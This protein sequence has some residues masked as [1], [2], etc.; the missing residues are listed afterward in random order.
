M[1]ALTSTR[2]TSRAWGWLLAATGL[3]ALLLAVGPAHAED[4]AIQ[5]GQRLQGTLELPAEALERFR[6]VQEK[7]A[8]LRPGTPLESETWRGTPVDLTAGGSPYTLVLK[9][10]AVAIADGDAGVRMQ[11]SW[12][13]DG[14]TTELPMP[15]MAQKG[16]RAGQVVELVGVSAPMG[17]NANRQGVPVVEFTTAANLRLERVQIDVW[18]GQRAS[19]PV[20][21]VMSWMPMLFGVVAL[22]FFLWLRRM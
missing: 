1:H 4:A 19:Q 8:Q 16:V 5:W 3:W 10:R 18:S 21:K 9:A 7:N 22:G 11:A 15:G 2:R 17:L 13:F 20:E 14:G 12:A 6:K